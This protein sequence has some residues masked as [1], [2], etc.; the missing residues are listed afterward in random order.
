MKKILAT[1]A[2]VISIQTS[3][4]QFINGTPIAELT[5]PYM[6]IT[7]TKTLNNKV[8]V[9]VDY[10]QVD[11]PLTPKD[12]VLLDQDGRSYV[13]NSPIDALN[14]FSL[15]GYELVTSYTIKQSGQEV[16]ILKYKEG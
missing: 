6:K 9:Q 1:I 4:A 3:N 11:K 7:T 16:F 15:I 2:L 14:L 8:G 10:G 13:L 5:V 12:N